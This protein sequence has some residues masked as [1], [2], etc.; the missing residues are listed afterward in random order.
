MLTLE[1]LFRRMTHH[2]NPHLCR[3]ASGH[4][5]PRAR[6]PL[7]WFT[8]VA[9][10]SSTS[11]KKFYNSTINSLKINR[12]NVTLFARCRQ[13]F[14]LEN[15]YTYVCQYVNTYNIFVVA[16]T[17]RKKNVRGLKNRKLKCRSLKKCRVKLLL[18]LPIVVF[19]TDSMYCNIKKITSCIGKLTNRIV[20]DVDYSAG[21]I[22]SVLPPQ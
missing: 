7:C 3:L 9:S 16:E 5:L 4:T 14:S 6:E 1:A 22:C 13:F 12:N 19:W 20:S 21:F 2:T 18:T 15:V 8:V 10:S 17:T 11:L